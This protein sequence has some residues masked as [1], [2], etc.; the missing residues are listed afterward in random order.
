MHAQAIEELAQC[1]SM[2]GIVS[3]LMLNRFA[4]N[5]TLGSLVQTFHEF[6]CAQFPQLSEAIA[7]TILFGITHCNAI[8][9]I[10]GRH[11]EVKVKAS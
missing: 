8:G 6:I 4:V 7:D 3:E 11:C 1:F 5:Q 2:R 10:H 9:E